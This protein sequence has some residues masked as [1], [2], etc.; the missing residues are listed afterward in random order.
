MNIHH[1]PEKPTAEEMVLI[2]P[3]VEVLD[4]ETG[5]NLQLLLNEHLQAGRKVIIALRNVKLIDSM[6]LASLIA[7]QKKALQQGGVIVLVEVSDHVM[8]LFKLVKL[9]NM[10]RICDGLNEA[11]EAITT[12]V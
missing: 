2:I 12:V 7:S 5:P 8:Q 3:T 9:H 4:I 6:G 10:I 1:K 11:V